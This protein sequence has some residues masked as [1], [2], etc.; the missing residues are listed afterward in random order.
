MLNKFFLTVE[1]Q[2]RDEHRLEYHL[3][4]NPIAEKWIKKIKHISKV[5]FDRVYSTPNDNT[6]REEINRNITVDIKLLNE[7]IGQIY[8]IKEEY[9]QLDCNLLHSFT[10]KHQY[11]YSV[12]VRD[13]FHSLHRKIHQLERSFSSTG[14]NWLPCE[15]GEKGGP[16]TT[17]HTES[18]YAYYELN[19]KAGN[20]YQQWS[21]FGKTPYQYWQ[22]H[23]SNDVDHFL[24]NCCPHTTFRPN[25][26]VFLQDINYNYVDAEFETWFTDYQSAWENKYHADKLSVYGHGGVLLA[27]PAANQFNDFSQ[28][29]SIKSIDLV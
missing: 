10:V 23:D 12:D 18:P 1:D 8:D 16:I 11:N 27:E 6:T 5:P 26:S 25:F 15:W 19:M 3:A 4:N 20:I 28:I 7:R 29:Y 24:Q 14:N 17:M 22:D 2:H 13:I 21:E 9:S